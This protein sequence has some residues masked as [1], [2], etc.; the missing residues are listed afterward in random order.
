MKKKIF[1]VIL[2]TLLALNVYA[3]IAGAIS[4]NID[5][6]NNS[7]TKLYNSDINTVEKNSELYGTLGLLDPRV[8]WIPGYVSANPCGGDITF[9]ATLWKKGLGASCCEMFFVWDTT[10]HVLWTAY[11]HETSHITY[12]GLCPHGFSITDC[13]GTRG[14]TYFTKAVAINNNGF[15]HQTPL[16]YVFTVGEPYVITNS[17]TNIDFTSATLNGNLENGGFCGGSTCDVWFVYDTTPHNSS[18]QYAYSTTHQTKT[19]NGNFYQDISGLDLGTTYYYRAVAQNDVKKCTGSEKKFSTWGACYS[20]EDSDGGGPG[21]LLNFD[22]SCS[23]D[24]AYFTNYDWDWNNDGEYDLFDTDPYCSHD[25][26]DFM[27]HECTLRIINIYG[28]TDTV[29]KVVNAT[30]EN[31]PV[32]C[33]NWEDI[34]GHGPGTT[35][36]FNASCS[37]SYNGTIDLYEWDFTSD[38]IY[39]NL[40]SSPFTSYTYGNYNPHDCTLRVTNNDGITAIVVITVQADTDYPPVANY[41]WDDADLGGP[42][43][44]IDFDASCSTDDIGIDLYEWDWTNDGSVNAYSS[45]PYISHDYGDYEEHYCKL[46]V[47][48][49]GG[50]KDTIIKTVQARANSNPN[51]PLIN[52]PSSG[53]NGQEYDFTFIATDPDNDDLYYQI[54]WGDGVLLD[55]FGPFESDEVI[56]E[57]H[58]WGEQGTF[59]IKA[60]VKDKYNAQ[61]DWATFE[62]SMPRFVLFHNSWLKLFVEKLPNYLTALKYLLAW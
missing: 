25:Y 34:D 8:S 54:D 51:P 48:D 46:I 12:C 62:V 36:D 4:K 30:V 10:W 49:T 52:G 55:W 19:T 47:T 28:Q 24:P 40:S 41:I 45:F 16:D 7:E 31:I 17:A 53:K 1:V 32:A 23:G 15:Q 58:T 33:F 56:T 14:T 42:G 6:E 3:S 9:Q 59:T 39:D 38:G 26:Q 43:T 13:C 61:S 2:S 60:R 44:Q 57:S 29:T 22:A 18:S 5:I 27:Q 21:S 35:I 37:Y 50:Q 20:W 11:A